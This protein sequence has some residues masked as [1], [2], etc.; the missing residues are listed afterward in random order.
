MTI[1]TIGTA[2]TARTA[3]R[4]PVSSDA[5]VAQ[6][7]ARAPATAV[8]TANA[9]KASA[10]VPTLDQVNEAVSQ[11]NKSV[12]AKSQGLEFSVDSDTKR[13]VV[14]VIDQSTK[15]VLRQIP[16]PEA[17]EIAKSLESKS[18]TGLLISQTA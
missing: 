12:Q 9:V 4:A 1:D 17:L 13:T 7:A 10:A 6:G 11:L 14:K 8:E 15:E 2:T 5:A 16:S 18:G 3:D